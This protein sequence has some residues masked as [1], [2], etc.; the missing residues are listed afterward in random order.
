MHEMPM[1]EQTKP[2]V[3]AMSWHMKETTMAANMTLTHTCKDV[4]LY[5]RQGENETKITQKIYQI[6]TE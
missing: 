3:F 1:I 2:H 4:L 5:S 6:L